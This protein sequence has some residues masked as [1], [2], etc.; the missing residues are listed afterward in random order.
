[1]VFKCDVRTLSTSLIL[2]VLNTILLIIIIYTSL[3]PITASYVVVILM[4]VPAVLGYSVGRSPR[5]TMITSEYLFLLLAV[6]GL[7]NYLGIPL[8]VTLQLLIIA[9]ASYTL[10]LSLTTSFFRNAVNDLAYMFKFKTYTNLDTT[11]KAL[12]ELL[13]VTGFLLLISSVTVFVGFKP[14]LLLM[15]TLFNFKYNLYDIGLLIVFIV[16]AVIYSMMV[17]QLS[18]RY[19]IISNFI[20]GGISSLIP[21]SIP[22]LIGITSA[23]YSTETAFVTKKEVEKQCIMALG[24]IL[25]AIPKGKN[26]G[27]LCLNPVYGENNHILVVG[28][29]GTGKTTLVKQLLKQLT[30]KGFRII[31]VDPH[32]EY[33]EF[34]DVVEV[35]P[36]SNPIDVISMLRKGVIDINEI[37]NVI[38]DTFKLGDVQ[39]ETLRKIIEILLSKHDRPT[40]KDLLDLMNE[41]L[42]TPKEILMN[43]YG[44]YVDHHN[45]RSLIPYMRALKEI[46]GEGVLG[47]TGISEVITKP[48]IINLRGISGLS[49]MRVYV[50][51]MLRLIFN[52]LKRKTDKLTFIVVEEFHNF[53]SRY[54]EGVLGKI[55]REGRKFG[56][57]VIAVT[58]SLSDVSDAILGNFKWFMVFP[59][60]KGLMKTTLSKLGISENKKVMDKINQILDT[61]KEFEFLT[62]SR[63]SGKVYY[64]KVY[65]RS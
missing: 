10:T 60:V 24:K 56:I 53:I 27:E 7:S 31:V 48:L 15:S 65:I 64:V 25:L 35:N 22:L 41:L 26:L 13:G 52:E 19:S 20:Y 6:L 38:T 36:K 50:E 9:I 3:T 59:M 55:L 8:N 23:M 63:G 57:N 5:L 30:T 51:I 40:L 39:R 61:M 49:V 18:L 34:K 45:I 47:P 12:V 37:V 11:K 17:Q 16:A 54:R 2:T 44:L 42:L 58:Q 21:V 14:N 29:T 28:A 62:W 43:K 46:M 32:G 4:I 1:M 33:L